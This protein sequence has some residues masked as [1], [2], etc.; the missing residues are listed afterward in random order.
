MRCERT[1]LDRYK[2]LKAIGFSEIQPQSPAITLH[3]VVSVIILVFVTFTTC[4]FV[5]ASI[6]GSD[7]A[8]GVPKRL[9][10]SVMI[11]L[12]YGCAVLAA[13]APKAKWTLF[14]IEADNERPVA[15]YLASVLISVFL[16]VIIQVCY[17]SI[18]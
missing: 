16:T 9:N 14:R 1:T 18:S 7:T 5:S 12:I 10:L 13:I 8:I 4:V 11:S 2:R 15:G 6:M 3:Q 17:K